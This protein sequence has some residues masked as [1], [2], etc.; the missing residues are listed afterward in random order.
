MSNLNKTY[1]EIRARNIAGQ[2]EV[3]CLGTV[4]KLRQDPMVIKQRNLVTFTTRSSA[5]RITKR[6]LHLVQFSREIE[7]N[8]ER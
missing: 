4:R 5:K 7:L 6:Y 2:R 3:L 8:N 1:S